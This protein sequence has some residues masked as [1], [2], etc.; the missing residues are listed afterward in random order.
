MEIC[1]ILKA[2]EDRLIKVQKPAPSK[3]W[4]VNRVHKLVHPSKMSVLRQQKYV[5]YKVYEV[6]L[7]YVGGEGE[8][9]DGKEDQLSGKMSPFNLNDRRRNNDVYFVN[10]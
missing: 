2:Q 9:R 5:K 8:L 3:K 4:R 1:S 6:G 10:S 7:R